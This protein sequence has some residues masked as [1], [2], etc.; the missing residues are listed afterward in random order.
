[1]NYRVPAIETLID[2]LKTDANART[3]DLEFSVRVRISSVSFKAIFNLD[4]H[5]HL[6]QYDCI[7]PRAFTKLHIPH[8][9][10]SDLFDDFLHCSYQISSVCQFP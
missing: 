6:P 7:A 2:F 3:I 10:K 1:M 5:Y 8:P 9:E 4:R